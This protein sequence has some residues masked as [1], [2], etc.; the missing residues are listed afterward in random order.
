MTTLQGKTILITGADGGIGR[1]TTLGLARLGAAMVMACV[2]PDAAAPV[3]EK[4]KRESANP[5]IDLLQLDLSS[6]AAIRDCARRVAG[7]YDRL[8]VLINNAGVFC[9]Q[10]QETRDGLEMSMGVNYFGPFLLTN[11]LLPLVRKAPAG[12]I[13]NVSSNGHFQ[14]RLDMDD[15]QIQK[16]YKSMKAYSASKLALVLFSRE[17][18]ERVQGDGIS[19]NAVHPGS[20]ATGI[21]NLWPGTWYQA[22]MT[23]LIGWFMASPQKGSEASI[24]LAGS[25]AVGSVTGKY[26][27]QKKL[28]EPSPQARDAHLQKALWRESERLTGLTPP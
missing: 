4:I 10:R 2:D 9:M 14:G 17:L 20:T 26:F 12:R 6:L 19:V 24:Y 8:D 11:L 28:K 18:A 21:W 15:L 22:V 25:E 16:G 27:S 1:E 23:K 3:C 13:I 7:K 5:H